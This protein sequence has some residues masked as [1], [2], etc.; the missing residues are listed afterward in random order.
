MSQDYTHACERAELLG[1]SK[2]TEEEWRQTQTEQGEGGCDDD[3]GALQVNFARCAFLLFLLFAPATS[4]DLRRSRANSRRVPD[5]D[6]SSR[7]DVV[8]FYS[9]LNYPFAINRARARL[10]KATRVSF[11]LIVNRSEKRAPACK[12]TYNTR[13]DKILFLTR[14]RVTC[15]YRRKERLDAAISQRYRAPPAEESDRASTCELN[16]RK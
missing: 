4:R 6:I 10:L 3:D 16:R 1:L 13:S 5:L 9:R 11:V 12:Y 7:R 15:L 14:L 2:P 8:N